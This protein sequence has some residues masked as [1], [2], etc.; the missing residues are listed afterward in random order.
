MDASAVRE[1]PIEAWWRCKKGFNRYCACM[2]CRFTPIA[3]ERTGSLQPAATSRKPGLPFRYRLDI[4]CVETCSGDSF[5]SRNLDLPCRWTLSGQRSTYRRPQAADRQ[6]RTHR[7]PSG[8]G[9]LSRS[10][11]RGLNNP[12]RSIWRFRCSRNS[13]IS[14][15]AG[16]S[17]TWE[18]ASSLARRI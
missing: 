4:R 3:S 17:S 18:W 15:C 11:R 6:R 16:M 7:L 13:K 9:G 10:G 12:T 2:T 1:I 14:P 5:G 8:S